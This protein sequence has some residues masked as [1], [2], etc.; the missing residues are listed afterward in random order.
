[1]KGINLSENAKTIVYLIER[2]GISVLLC[3]FLAWMLYDKFDKFQ[4]TQRI[5]LRNQR[6]MMDHFKIKRPGPIEPE[7]DRDR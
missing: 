4:T 5:L 3:G 1:M 2:I 7:R 6:A